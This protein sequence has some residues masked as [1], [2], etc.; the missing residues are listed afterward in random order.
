MGMT[1]QVSTVSQLNAP[2]VNAP[3]WVVQLRSTA[4]TDQCRNGTV[5]LPTRMIFTGTCARLGFYST[6]RLMRSATQ[7]F[8]RCGISK[9]RRLRSARSG[10]PEHSPLCA[11]GMYGF[12]SKEMFSLPLPIH[13]ER[14]HQVLHRQMRRVLPVQDGFNDRW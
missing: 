12:F 2:M 11:S 14:L 13:G 3:S 6:V 5:S 7:K 10:H 9:R 4:N 8:W 1:A